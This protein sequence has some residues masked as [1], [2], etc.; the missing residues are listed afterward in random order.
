MQWDYTKGG[1]MYAVTPQIFVARGVTKDSDFDRTL[2]LIYPG[3]DPNGNK[4]TIQLPSSTAFFDGSLDADEQYIFDA[5]VVRFR[6]V[7]LSYSLPQDLL[8]KFHLAMFAN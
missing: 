5:T 3:V 7:S 2:P 1:D 4:N 8:E 6:E